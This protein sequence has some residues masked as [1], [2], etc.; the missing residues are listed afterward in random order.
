M[1]AVEPSGVTTGIANLYGIDDSGC[2]RDP[3]LTLGFRGHS[4]VLKPYVG[5][6]IVHA[7]KQNRSVSIA[8]ARR[9]RQCGLFELVYWEESIHDVL[10]RVVGHCSSSSQY[11]IHFGADE[12]TLRWQGNSNCKLNGAGAKVTLPQ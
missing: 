1:L 10:L 9:V 12:V 6:S 3:G 5:P 11:I 8:G 4:I 2:L 7:L